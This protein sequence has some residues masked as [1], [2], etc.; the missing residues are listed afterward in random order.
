MWSAFGIVVKDLQQAIDALVRKGRRVGRLTSDDLA[1]GLAGFDLGPETFNRVLKRLVDEGVEVV[2]EADIEAENCPPAQ[3]DPLVSKVASPGLA[4]TERRL[5]TFLFTD[6]E[7]RYVFMDTENYNQYSFS[8]PSALLGE[9][10][11]R[12]GCELIL[13]IDANDELVALELVQAPENEEVL[14]RILEAVS[15]EKFDATYIKVLKQRT[16][17]A[18]SIRDIEAEHRRAIYIFRNDPIALVVEFTRRGTAYSPSRPRR[19]PLAELVR[20]TPQ[21]IFW[22]SVFEPDCEAY[23]GPYGEQAEFAY[24]E[25]L[26]R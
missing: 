14:H 13:T 23:Q 22:R 26:S 4:R 7:E 8:F 25:L 3:V 15:D 19:V 16:D 24:R 11:L 6:P 1:Q 9:A 2:D 18:R 12:D 20:Q 17:G 21:R 10:Q 5:A